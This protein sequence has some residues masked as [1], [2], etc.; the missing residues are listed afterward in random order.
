[1]NTIF[2]QTFTKY[3]WWEQVVYGLIGGI[4]N[5][6]LNLLMKNVLFLPVFM[7]TIFTVAC[8]FISVWSCLIAAFTYHLIEEV[9]KHDFLSMQFMICSFLIVLIIR[10]TLKKKKKTG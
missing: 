10:V 3:F 4:I 9:I 8:S 7:D 6:L 5:C 1:M 2:P